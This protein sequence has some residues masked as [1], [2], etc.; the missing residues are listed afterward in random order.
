MS[1]YNQLI[2]GRLLKINEEKNGNRFAQRALNDFYHVM[3]EQLTHKAFEK[4]TVNKICEACN[5][6]RSTFYNYFEDLNDLM[7]YCWTRV[8]R[9]AGIEDYIELPQ[10]RQTA[11]LFET[12]YSYMELKRDFIQRLLVHN[13][14]EGAM[15][16]SL[17][18]F[19]KK[20]IYSMVV[21]CP[22]ACEY[23]I[24]SDIMAEH[25]GNTVQMLLSRS[26]LSRR[27]ISKEQAIAY[28]DYLLGTLERNR[29]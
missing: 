2:G 24:P 27:P 11:Y 1:T 7:N 25:Y 14:Y 15:I 22:A 6:P 9:E 16:R 26:F 23:S 12:L 17:T 20:A 29:E 19:M 4:I 5:Y 10:E 3:L 28:L 21:N 13:S 18:T 8:A